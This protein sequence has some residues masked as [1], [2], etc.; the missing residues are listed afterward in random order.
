MDKLAIKTN[1]HRRGL[2][3]MADLPPAAASDF[4]YVTGEDQYSP[5]FFRYRD[6]W[7]DVDEFQRAPAIGELSA[8][9][10]IHPNSYFSG[11]AVKWADDYESVIAARYYSY[12]S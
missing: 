12:Y 4:D 10:G 1:G 3:C 11:V 9:D 7:Y 5:R 8:Y 6:A 2:V